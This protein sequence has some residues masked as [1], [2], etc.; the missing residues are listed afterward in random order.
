MSADFIKLISEIHRERFLVQVQ[1][2]IINKI[3]CGFFTGFNF[4]NN[5]ISI[6]NNLRNNGFNVT[7]ICCIDAISD[8]GGAENLNLPIVSIED[9]PKFENKPPIML[10][11]V[12]EP[13]DMVFIEYF[14]KFDIQIFRLVN[15][16]MF[17]NPYMQHLEELYKVYK[18]FDEEESKKVFLA[19]IK[20]KITEQIKDFR[21]APEP[22]YFLEGFFPAEGDIAIDGGSYDG[23]TS[24][25]F[26]MCGAKVYAFEMDAKNYKNCIPLAEKYNFV[27]EN[28]GLSNQEGEEF[29]NSS[30][31]SSK[32]GMGN[33][34]GK[35]I[36]LD[37]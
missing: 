18:M 10:Y 34:V 32:K 3:P 22:Q 15:E 7:C 8:G 25:D 16:E 6:A 14:S 23:A 9:F 26:A 5:A 11:F 28:L 30:G 17:Y 24:R 31:T 1:N 33:L 27:I 12:L 37:T 19:S 21:C 36:D 2:L 29:Y 20:G 4:Q 13:K 35:F